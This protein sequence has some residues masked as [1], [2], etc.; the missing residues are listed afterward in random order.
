MVIPRAL[1]FLAFLAFAT[2]T[3]AADTGPPGMLVNN[4]KAFGAICDGVRRSPD[5]GPAIQAA[6]DAS[7]GASG[8][9]HG[10]HFNL[11]VPLYFPPGHC[12]ISSPITFKYVQGGHIFGAGRFAS[13][14]ENISGTGIFQTNGFEYSIVEN[15]NL[16]D[17]GKTAAVIDLDWDGTTIALQS[18]TFRD[19]YISGGGVGVEIGKTGFMGSENLFVNDFVSRAAIAG[20]QTDNYNALQNTIIGGNIATNPIG[21]KM[22]QGTVSVYNT[23]FQ[24]N[25]V[26]DIQQFNSAYDAIVISGCRTESRNFF[27]GGNHMTVKIVG[28]SQLN[29]SPGVFVQHSGY[30]SIDSSNSVDG[31]IA[32]SNRVGTITNSSFGRSD[33]IDTS[34]LS[35]TNL[36]I[37][38]VTYGYRGTAIYIPRKSYGPGGASWPTTRSYIPIPA[39]SRS[40]T[41]A[42]PANSRVIAV[43]LILDSPGSAGTLNVGD[44][45]NQTR[46]FRGQSLTGANATSTVANVFYNSANTITATS[47]RASGVTGYVAIDYQVLN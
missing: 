38:S 27:S 37:S 46:Y 9:P 30:L 3:V 25:S 34:D 21:V 18:N 29:Y 43:T 22:V 20:Y 11:N 4:V 26:W 35:R 1:T 15:L 8:S 39:G 42:V 10:I 16:Q 14:I 44:T 19:L 45:A 28:V 31:Q 40:A 6:A 2:P 36:A 41:F 5:D 33:W 47:S 32:S 23:G 17:D 24:Q 7:F 13:K 12:I